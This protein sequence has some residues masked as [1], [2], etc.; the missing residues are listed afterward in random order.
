M[1]SGAKERLVQITGPS[2]DNI[3]RAKSLIEDTIRRNASPVPFEGSM[4]QSPPA[5]YSQISSG[6]L[7]NP[8][9][10]SRTTNICETNFIDTAKSVTPYSFTLNINGESL[11]VTSTS[12][13][14]ANRAK[15]LLEEQLHLRYFDMFGIGY[16]ASDSSDSDFGP[17]KTD[18][19]TIHQQEGIVPLHDY[20]TSYALQRQHSS[21]MI[22]AGDANGNRHSLQRSAS[23]GAVTI[24][25]TSM[26]YLNAEVHDLYDYDDYSE[27]KN[28]KNI[29]SYEREFL[30]SCSKSPLSQTMPKYLQ[31]LAKTIPDI[32][33]NV[34]V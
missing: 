12:Y 15:A 24:G 4:M 23:Q 26:R 34:S 8:S 3:E 5:I 11:T 20:K 7:N 1:N 17:A 10:M 14:V 18:F 13:S 21:S 28:T 31:E 19:R 2:E 27:S 22:P 6:N 16:E 9:V 32:V 25:R 30:M 33:R 29:I